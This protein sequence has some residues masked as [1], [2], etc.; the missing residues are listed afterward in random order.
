MAF[1]VNEYDRNLISQLS[2]KAV[3]PAPIG[4]GYFNGGNIPFQF[5][6]R[7]KSDSK[8]GNW[9]EIDVFTYEPQVIFWGAN[10]RKITLEITYVATGGDWTTRK[11]SE[12]VKDLRAILYSDVKGTEL[13]MWELNLYRH[14]PTSDEI[15]TWRTISASEKPGDTFITIEGFTYAFRTDIT[16]ELQMITQIEKENKKHQALKNA[17][18][19]PKQLWY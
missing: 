3:G 6:P 17:R 4:G 1:N 16:M 15:S 7:I 14:I 18:K 5:P 2:M 10:A 13:P 11:I 19:K 8:S 12:I 9:Q